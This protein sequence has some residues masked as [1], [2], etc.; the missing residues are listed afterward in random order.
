MSS[1]ESNG[2]DKNGVAQ[3]RAPHLWEALL[4][5]L[6]LLL[7]IGVGYIT[8]ELPVE[9]MILLAAVVA[10]MIAI[11]RLKYTWDDLMESVSAK[12]A[13]AWPALLILLMVGFLIG[14]WMAGGSIPYMIYWGLKIIDPQYLALIALV[15]TSIVSLTTGTSWGSAGTIGVAF[16]GVAIGMEANLAMV[17]GAVVAGAYFGD[18]MSPL[19][20]TTNLASMITNVNI[21]THIKNM[22]W[23][24]GPAFILAGVFYLVVG[25]TNSTTAQVPEKVGVLITQLEAGFNF[26]LL[27]LVPVVVVIVGAAMQFPTI[28]VMFVS[29]LLAMVNAA[30]FQKISIQDNVQAIING[31]NLEM[32]TRSEWAAIEPLEDM[33]RLLE[34]GGMNSMLGTLLIAFCA[35]L[36]AGIMSV[37]GSLEMI[38]GKIL[39][40]VKSRFGLI[41]SSI[42]ICLGTTGV[43]SNGQISIIM[44]GEVLRPEYIKR[45]LHPK[46]LSRTIEDSVSV[47]ECLMPWTAAGAYM[48]ST[49]GVATLEY[50]PWAILNWSGMIF[51]LIL[52]AT[53]LGITYL[54]KEEQLKLMEQEGLTAD[55]ILIEAKK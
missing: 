22:L 42:G 37:S 31:F 17:A 1:P 30:I 50:L 28:P 29:S 54:T 39:K 5:I 38:T 19:S 4:P 13:K 15:V 51:A 46:V 23:T 3:R 25:L 18:K 35:I 53:G 24:T 40:N 26:N 45:G 2:A 52:A 14:A 47:T 9:P 21:F 48:A 27:L 16:M 36:F 20:D 10:S 6:S 11:L 49:L 34:R 55:D 12:M 41:A 44:P 8:L 33:S 43:T 7:F 32:I